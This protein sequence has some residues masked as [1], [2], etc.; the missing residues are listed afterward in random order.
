MPVAVVSIPAKSETVISVSTCEV[1]IPRRRKDVRMSLLHWSS[2]RFSIAL[3]DICH[4]V[5][6][7]RWLLRLHQQGLD[8]KPQRSSQLRIDPCSEE[9]KYVWSLEAL[10]QWREKWTVP[11]WRKIIQRLG[12]YFLASLKNRERPHVSQRI[13]LAGRNK[14]ARWYLWSSTVCPLQY[15]R[16]L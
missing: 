1:S 5:Q 4:N 11:W 6:K 9:S 14:D 8:N 7:L 12:A 13:Q 3:R 2:R 16:L 10:L 15:H